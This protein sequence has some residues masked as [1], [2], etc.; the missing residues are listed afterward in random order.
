MP[1]N[2]GLEITRYGTPP[3]AFQKKIQVM[4]RTAEQASIDLGNKSRDHMRTVITTN[5]KR[6][7]GSTGNLAKSIDTVVEAGGKVVGVGYI[8]EMDQIAP[9]WYLVNYG[10]M[11]AAAR[12]G[13]TLM[14]NFEGSTPSSKND[15]TQSF[16]QTAPFYPMT[17]KKPVVAMNYISK[18][19][20]WVSTIWR[21]HYSGRLNKVSISKFAAGAAMTLG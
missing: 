3:L 13:R 17:P 20:S 4:F 5:I 6:K 16:F 8:P 15:G 10:G 11:N 19:A 18:T 14:G 1:K 7:A 12:Q 2:I 9:Y 21:I